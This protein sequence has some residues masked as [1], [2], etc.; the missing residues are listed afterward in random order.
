MIK[1]WGF[2]YANVKPYDFDS[3]PFIVNKHSIQEGYLTSEPYAVE[4]QG[5]FKPNVFLLADR[6]YSTYSS[7]IEARREMVERNPDLVQRFVN[8]SAIGWY[9]YLYGDNAEANEA[10]K[11]ANPGLTDGQIAYSIAKLK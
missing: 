8:A 9:H 1:A 7:L 4:Q 2:S 11:R 3:A 10:I 6:G 5:H